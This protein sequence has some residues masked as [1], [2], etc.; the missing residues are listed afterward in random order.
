MYAINGE[1]VYFKPHDYVSIVNTPNVLCYDQ[2]RI[3]VS[4]ENTS[5]VTANH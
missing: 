1:V 2:E 4:I 5:V 3:R